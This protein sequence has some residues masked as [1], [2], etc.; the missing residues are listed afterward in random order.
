M[1]QKTTDMDE[2]VALEKSY[3]DAMKAKDG[4][5]TAALSAPRA[6]VIG[7]RGATSIAKDKMGEMTESADWKLHSYQFDAI[8]VAR[9]TPDV[10]IIVYTV[11]QKVTMNG[12][13]Q[14][15]RAAESSTWIKGKDGWQCHAHCESMLQDEAA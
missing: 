10:A 9:P 2:I 5:T 13:E 11:D 8:D 6:L 1:D 7:P 3:W 4:A 12:K 15:M 14:K